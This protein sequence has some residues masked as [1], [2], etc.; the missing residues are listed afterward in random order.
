MKK[1]LHTC[2]ILILISFCL[3]G[4][5]FIG[6]KMT[7]M[8]TIYAAAAIISFLLLISFNYLVHKGDL[9]YQLLFG[10]I[11]IVNLGYFSLS[12]SKTLEEALLANRISYFGS[13]FLPMSMFLLILNVTK[14]NY[15]NWLHGVLLAISV[16]VFL[17][18]ASPGFSTIYYKEVSLSI[19][20]GAAVLEKVYGPLHSI[21]LYY[22]LGYFAVMVT[23]VVYAAVKKKMGSTLQ[24]VMLLSA[25]LI[26]ILVWLIEQLVPIDFEMLS[27]SYIISELFLIALQVMIIEQEKL[28]ALSQP[29]TPE[30]EF[31]LLEHSIVSEQELVIPTTAEETA[32][33]LVIPI[34]TEEA[35]ELVAPTNAEETAEL[36]APTN[37]EEA[38]E[39]L[40]E[41]SV[42]SNERIHLFTDGLKNLTP[43]ERTIYNL[44]VSGNTTKEILESLGI[45]ENTLK[46]HNKNIYGKLGVTSRKQLLEISKQF[47]QS[48]Q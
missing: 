7:S 11:F 24:A 38:A 13:V 6:D 5:G 12:I 37:T 9:W 27:I 48:S 28:L 8:S 29:S 23:A 43:T 44:Y 15:K 19:Q 1:L 41:I 45:K 40:P 25:V 30:M 22:L 35:A 14:I 33:E 3:T 39:F 18:A 16:I 20:N 2:P 34:T 10:S 42:P 36:V 31:P 26:N 32:S 17:I 4:C 21:Y 46:F 47:E